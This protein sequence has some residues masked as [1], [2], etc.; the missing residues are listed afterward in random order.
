MKVHGMMILAGA[1]LVAGCSGERPELE[2]PVAAGDTIR[3]SAGPCFGV[4]PSYSLRVTPDG[5]GLLEPERFTSVPGATRFTVTPAQYRRFR[6]ALAQFRPVAG[7]VKRISSGENCTRF[8]TDMP[9]YTIEWTRDERPATRLEFQSGCM[10][11]SYG[12]LR[13]TIAA[14]PRM[15][16]IDAMVKP[17]AVR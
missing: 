4:C 15:L 2:K 5:S 7:T 9:G 12:K 8:A 10:D 13:A 6:S 3:F 14:I 16:D 1:A 17:S 11:A